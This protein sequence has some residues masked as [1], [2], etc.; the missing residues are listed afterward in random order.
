MGY[1]SIAPD[2]SAIA[3]QFLNTKQNE[4]KEKQQLKATAARSG[5]PSQERKHIIFMMSMDS[6][7]KGVI[8]TK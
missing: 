2:L 7:L 3:L 5:R 6:K 4:K 8:D 1:S